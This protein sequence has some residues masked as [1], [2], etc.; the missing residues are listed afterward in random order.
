MKIYLLFK[1]MVDFTVSCSHVSFFG[2]YEPCLMGSSTWVFSRSSLTAGPIRLHHQEKGHWFLGKNMA[3][4]TPGFFNG[5]KDGEY[6]CWLMLQK[7]QSTRFWTHRSLYPVH[8]RSEKLL[9]STG[10][11]DCFQTSVY[12]LPTQLQVGDK[13]PCLMSKLPSLWPVGCQHTAA[14]LTKT[15]LFNVKTSVLM[16]CRLPTYSCKFHKNTPVWCP[17]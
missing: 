2:G 6:T 9:S 7:S 3:A 1:K 10:E 16:T 8:K 15:P 12:A 5:K 11:P 17:D 4:F 13:H 14:S